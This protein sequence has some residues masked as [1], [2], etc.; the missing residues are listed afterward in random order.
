MKP[1]KLT[2]EEFDIMKTHSRIGGDAIRSA[3]NNALQIYMEQNVDGGP[4]AMAYLE[5]AEKI[6][7]YHHERWDGSGYPEGL[8]GEEIPLSARLMAVADV[9]DAL[10]SPRIYKEPWDFEEA[11]GHIREQ[12]G[13]HFDPDV[14][15][16]LVGEMDQFRDIFKMMGEKA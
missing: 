4:T 1:G 7:R 9:F 14:V 10:T 3:I 8:K 6:A 5:E 16:A 13:L 12:R 15:D 11:I 2:P